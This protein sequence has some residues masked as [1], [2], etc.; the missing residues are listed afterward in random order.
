[1]SW[2]ESGSARSRPS[3][4]SSWIFWGTWLCPVAWLLLSVAARQRRSLAAREGRTGV[5]VL[6]LGLAL[7]WGGAASGGALVVV[8]GHHLGLVSA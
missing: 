6:G 4:A 2:I 1:M 7:A 3:G 5:L 8:R